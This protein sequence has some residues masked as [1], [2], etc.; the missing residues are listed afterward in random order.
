MENE[1]KALGVGATLD[2]TKASTIILP[3]LG[4]RDA[5]IAEGAAFLRSQSQK[6]DPTGTGVPIILHLTSPGE[7]RVTLDL[8]NVSIADAAKYFTIAAGIEM[9]R[10]GEAIIFKSK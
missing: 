5:T 10:D 2:G 7:T 8:V 3:K 6:L 9:T 1:L 4:F